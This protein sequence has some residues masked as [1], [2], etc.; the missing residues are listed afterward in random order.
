L[1]PEAIV[2]EDRLLSAAAAYDVLKQACVVVDAGTA[3]TIDFV[4]GAGTFHG[5]AILPG[6]QVMLD[7][8]HERTAQL[9]EIVFTKPKEPIGHNTEQAMLTA[10][11]YG[12]RGAVRE[13]V[14][15]YAQVLGSFPIVVATGGDAE[16][17]FGDY[18]LVERI[19]PDL[20]L[21]GIA[22]TY[23]RAIQGES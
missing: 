4:D 10:V 13:L 1:D 12:V 8:L 21:M 18:E 14:E 9:P 15:Q 3:V 6:A 11:F 5:G 16:M 19:V 7:S 23:D 2:G 20:G 17:L 22:L